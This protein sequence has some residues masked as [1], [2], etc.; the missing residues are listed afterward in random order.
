MTEQSL[1]YV[2][3]KKTGDLL[4]ANNTDIADLQ[5]ALTEAQKHAAAQEARIEELTQQRDALTA[6]I[7]QVGIIAT[8]A[9][10]DEPQWKLGE[11]LTEIC[12]IYRA[13]I[14]PYV[15]R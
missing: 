14:A 7:Q 4:A 10:I 13:A 2:L 9:R 1:E 8:L 6:A 3:A 15:V 11:R 12:K 5:A